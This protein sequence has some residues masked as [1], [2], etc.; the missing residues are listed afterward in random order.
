MKEKRLYLVR[1]AKSSWSNARQSDFQRPLSERGLQAAPLMARRLKEREEIPSLMVSSP[2]KRAITTALLF[3]E[4]FGHPE[5]AIERKMEIYTGGAEAL[6]EIVRSLPEDCRSA[7]LF[8]HNPSMT[9]FS[10]L[11]SGE[12][13]ADMATCGVIC[14]DMGKPLWREIGERSG[15][16]L[17]Y[18]YPAEKQR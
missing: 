8:G 11:L 1:H 17:W 7:M 3:A 5:E 9:I 18:D 13:L 15:R 14:I 4:T 16:R 12:Q 6:L 2:A 10:N